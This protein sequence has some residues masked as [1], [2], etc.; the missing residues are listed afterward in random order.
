M[1]DNA[2]NLY[3][4]RSRW[5]IGLAE[6]LKIH[7]ELA[8]EPKYGTIGLIAYPYYFLFE[9][10]SP[11]I[12]VFTIAFI[13]AA[14]FVGNPCKAEVCYWSA[15]QSAGFTGSD[16]HARV[17]PESISPACQV[18]GRRSTVARRRSRT[19]LPP[20]P[21]DRSEPCGCGTRPVF[22]AGRRHRWTGRRA[23]R[24]P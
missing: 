11:P 13:I 23:D 8:F 17:D 20:K 2:R 18:G 12:K 3:K 7:R 5:Q 22:A 16:R 19:T 1:P 4:Q 15:F 14:A 9:L 21:R 6:T 10:L 24:A